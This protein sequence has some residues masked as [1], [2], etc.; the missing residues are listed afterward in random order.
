MFYSIMETL[1]VVKKDFS[2]LEFKK[3]ASCV[4]VLTSLSV[5]MRAYCVTSL[6]LCKHAARYSGRPAKVKQ[7]FSYQ[8]KFHRRL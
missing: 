8:L 6:I 3:K 4:Q 5:N 1:A 2:A 7:L